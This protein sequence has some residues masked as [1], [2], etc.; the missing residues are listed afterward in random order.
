MTYY[1]K[2]PDYYNAAGY[3]STTYLLIYYDGYGYNFYYGAY[4][5][6]ENSPNDTLSA[7]EEG[8]VFVIGFAFGICV[9]FCV[10]QPLIKSAIE[11]KR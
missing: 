4:G 1:Y 8:I 10:I 3:Y 2:A 9:Y 11:R 5:Y 7:L 6:Y